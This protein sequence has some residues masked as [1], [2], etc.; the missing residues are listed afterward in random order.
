VDNITARAAD[1]APL[2]ALGRAAGARV[3]AYTMD[4]PV[5]LSLARNRSRE[6]RARVPD[7]AV[8]VA[9]K[10]FELPTRAEGFDAVYRVRAEGGAFAI[11][12]SE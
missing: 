9:S 12:P 11:V 2:V 10:R 6:G 1:R 4:T 7:V 3:V 5:K 8:F